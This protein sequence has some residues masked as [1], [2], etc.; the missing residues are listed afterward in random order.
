MYLILLMIPN[1]LQVKN[2]ENQKEKR[3]ENKVYEQFKFFES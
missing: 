2:L 1:Y 3:K